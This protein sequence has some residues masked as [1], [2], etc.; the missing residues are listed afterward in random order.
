MA[1]PED[2]AADVEWKRSRQLE[3]LEPILD[4]LG[5]T[6]SARETV[7]HSLR[8]AFAAGYLVGQEVAAS[9]ILRHQDRLPSTQEGE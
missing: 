6:G 5:L 1:N 2:I 3:L 8:H 4:G 9:I 7:A